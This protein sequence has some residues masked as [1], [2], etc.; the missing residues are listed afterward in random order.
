MACCYSSELSE[1]ITIQFSHFYLSSTGLLRW[2]VK[3]QISSLNS[4]LLKTLQQFTISFRLKLKLPKLTYKTFSELFLDTLAASYLAL[5]V[6]LFLLID[7]YFAATIQNYIGSH[8]H[9]SQ[10]LP[11]FFFGGPFPSFAICRPKPILWYWIQIHHI[12]PL[13]YH[14]IF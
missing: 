7:L 10:P 13:S 11:F 3:S 8:I 5:Q 9:S 12:N 1:T 6:K 4:F 14:L 2:F